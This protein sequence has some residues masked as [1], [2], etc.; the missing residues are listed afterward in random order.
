MRMLADIFVSFLLIDLA[1][2]V[3]V[4]IGRR[5]LEKKEQQDYL[6]QVAQRFGQQV[7]DAERYERGRL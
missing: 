4:G 7:A 2:F 5:R 3:V 6:K 1:F